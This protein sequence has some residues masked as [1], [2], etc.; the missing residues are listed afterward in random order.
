MRLRLNTEA[1]F[2]ICRSMY[3]SGELQMLYIITYRVE[4]VY[5]VQIEERIG[6]EA[7]TSV[8][9]NFDNNGIE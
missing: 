4:S 7:L 2:N 6:V 3:H 9:M 1:T 8:I 5:G